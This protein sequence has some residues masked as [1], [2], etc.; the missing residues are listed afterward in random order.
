MIPALPDNALR[1]LRK[2]GE[3]AEADV[4]AYRNSILA[5]NSP[6]VLLNDEPTFVTDRP[7]DTLLRAFEDW[8]RSQLFWRPQ[9]LAASVPHQGWFLQYDEHPLV[10]Q[11]VNELHTV[12]LTY[13]VGNDEESQ[14]YLKSAADALRAYIYMTTRMYLALLFR[15]PYQRDRAFALATDLLDAR[16][17]PERAGIYAGCYLYNLEVNPTDVL[18]VMFDGDLDLRLSTFGDVA[19]QAHHE[20]MEGRGLPP[21]YMLTFRRTPDIPLQ[22]AVYNVIHLDEP[23]FDDVITAFRLHARAY[24]GRGRRLSW[25]SG[26]PMS[27]GQG[28][29]SVDAFVAAIAAGSPPNL[30]KYQ[31]SAS[32]FEEVVKTY[33]E[34]RRFSKR[35]RLEVALT[36]F[37]N[38]YRTFDYREQIIDLVIAMENLFGEETVGQT[39]EVGYRLRMRAAR[40]L[41]VDADERKKLRKFFSDLYTLRSKIVHGDSGSAD[42]LVQKTF[43]KPL[44]EVADETQEIVR[45]TLLK[46]L[47]NPSQIGQEYLN[48]LLLGIADG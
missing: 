42:D 25:V 19:R 35:A 15:L 14:Y 31:M 16:I 28:P 40:Y 37:N 41:G 22:N 9:L 13:P 29:L 7:D 39:T 1:L 36:R 43:K 21:A 48:D 44:A 12:L 2:F 5:T 4:I 46:M 11:L 17:N 32:D 34:L 20:S 26:L 24:I 23:A 3:V 47:A 6:D 8:G 30:P 33:R 18:P 45:R 38:S 10:G 27:L